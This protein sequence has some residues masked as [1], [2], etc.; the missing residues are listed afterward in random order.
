MKGDR[1]ADGR[2]LYA[3]AALALAACIAA[4]AAAGGLREGLFGH[5]GSESRQLAPPPVARYVSEDGDSFVLDRTQGRTLLKFDDNP[6]VW[7]LAPFPAPRG[8]IIYKNDLGEPVLRATRL[9]GVT[10]FTDA[11]PGGAAAALA[12]GGQPIRL[13]P[14]GPQALLERLGQASLRASHAARHLVPF[15]A[16]ATPASS[17]LIADAALVASEAVVRMARRVDAKILLARLKQVRLAEGRRASVQFTH[18]ALQITVA[19]SQGLA[20]RPSSE[21]ILAVASGPARD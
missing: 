19:P 11:R 9:G 12:G 18:G 17:A 6:E 1:G 20:G 7:V 5:S 21:R 8:D 4:P 16:D 14:L 10:V 3:A 15:D 13:V 2:A